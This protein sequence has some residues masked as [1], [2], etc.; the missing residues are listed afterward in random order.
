MKKEAKTAKD[1]GGAMS[2]LL[3]LAVKDTTR[4]LEE[5]GAMVTTLRQEGKDLD[6]EVW[7]D[8]ELASI[9]HRL[10]SAQCRLGFLEDTL[11]QFCQSVLGDAP[12]RMEN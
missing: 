8:T 4:L 3:S 5:A 9:E 7:I 6:P 1:L 2:S 10:T 12:C 11:H